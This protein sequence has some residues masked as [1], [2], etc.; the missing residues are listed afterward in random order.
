MVFSVTGH[1]LVF[2]KSIENDYEFLSWSKSFSEIVGRFSMSDVDV[3]TAPQ[4]YN[5]C[6][7][8]PLKTIISIR[9][10]EKIDLFV[11]FLK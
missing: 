8:K 1:F 10:A 3:V 2:S 4:A 5:P 6:F 9:N 7:M 11:I